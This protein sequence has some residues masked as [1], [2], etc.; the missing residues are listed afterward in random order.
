[1]DVELMRRCF[2]PQYLM[3][4]LNSHPYYSLDEKVKLFRYHREHMVPTEPVELWDVR[5]TVAGDMGYDR[6][7]DLAGGDRVE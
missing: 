3:W 1:M 6:R 5:V 7:G 2:A 4:N